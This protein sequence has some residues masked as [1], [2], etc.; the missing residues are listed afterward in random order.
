LLAFRDDE[1]RVMIATTGDE[2]MTYLVRPGVPLYAAQL[3]A[4]ALDA[5]LRRSEA[6]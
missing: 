2:A 5:Q 6:A 1:A 3:H 4:H